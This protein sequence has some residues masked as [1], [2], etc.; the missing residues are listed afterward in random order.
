ML[1]HINTVAKYQKRSFKKMTPD[2]FEPLPPLRQFS[3]R[4]IQ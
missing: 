1:S 3:R 4:V 2:G